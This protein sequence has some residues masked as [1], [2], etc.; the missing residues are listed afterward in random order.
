MTR[1][2][3]TRA[4]FHISRVFPCNELTEASSPTCYT[5]KQGGR[6]DS[7]PVSTCR[8]DTQRSTWRGNNFGLTT[9]LLNSFFNAFWVKERSVRV[10]WSAEKLLRTSSDQLSFTCQDAIERAYCYKQQITVKKV[11]HSTKVY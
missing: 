2:E 10:P 11:V 8:F 4:A 7:N 9:S 5:G 6:T 1:T 3:R